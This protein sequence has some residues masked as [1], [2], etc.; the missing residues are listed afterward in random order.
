MRYAPSARGETLRALFPWQIRRRRRRQGEGLRGNGGWKTKK[1]KG[2][3]HGPITKRRETDEIDETNV[4]VSS[5]RND[6]C[7]YIADGSSV[8]IV[9]GESETEIR[10][11]RLL[12][13]KRLLSW[14]HSSDS[15]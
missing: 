11:T 1:K 6:T 9:R 13:F 15:V 8:K 7:E 2:I 10:R 4:R 14:V 5:P 3:E 12:K